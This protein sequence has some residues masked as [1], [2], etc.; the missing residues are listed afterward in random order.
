VSRHPATL[1][2]VTQALAV[3]SLSARHAIGPSFL[4]RSAP[5]EFEVALLDLDVDAAA[6]PAELCALVA[7]ALSD[8][9]IVVLAGSDGRRRLAQALAHGAVVGLV[10]KPSPGGEGAAAEGPDEQWL[11]L[12]L[13]R[14]S[15]DTHRQPLGPGPYLLAGAHLN[16]CVIG[17]SAAKDTALQELLTDAGR[18][19]FSDEKMRRVETAAD[20]LMLN[21]LYAAPRDE[22]GHPLYAD[23]DRRTPVSL[24]AQAQVRLRWGCDG[25]TF[26]ISVS[27]RFGSLTRAA[28]ATHVGRLHNPRPLGRAGGP[29]VGS[30]PLGGA[31][32][33]LALVLTVGNELALQVAPGRF[34]EATCAL[35]IAGSNRAALARGSSL[36]LYWM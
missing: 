28:V 17:G 24:A 18:F 26:A 20:E 1:K 36:H 14:H 9:P 15:S 7:A 34:T 22:H 31:G 21:A 19:G 13:R 11:G 10:P 33:G 35:Q 4:P 16:E 8:T 2:H 27:D 25:R 30:A 5:G 29:T 6:S 23:L 32:L 3:A 12:A